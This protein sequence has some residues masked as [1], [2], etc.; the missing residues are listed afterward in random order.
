MSDL[1][2]HTLQDQER[3][4]IYIK[5]NLGTVHPGGGRSPYKIG[6]FYVR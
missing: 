5:K 3:I 1:V 2:Y 4:S 6:V